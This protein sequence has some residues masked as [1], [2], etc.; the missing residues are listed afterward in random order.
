[1]RIQVHPAVIAVAEIE[2]PIQHQHFVPLQIL[3]RLLT[4]LVL[5]IHLFIWGRGSF[6]EDSEHKPRLQV[7]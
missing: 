4:N 6:K 2:V 5:S 7:S 1:M 3:E